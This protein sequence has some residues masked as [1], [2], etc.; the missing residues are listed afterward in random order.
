MYFLKKY[1]SLGYGNFRGLWSSYTEI[2]LLYCCSKK[3]E[4]RNQIGWLDVLRRRHQ[5]SSRKSL[6][7]AALH[8]PA[9]KGLLKFI[10][11]FMTFMKPWF[12]MAFSSWCIS[13]DHNYFYLNKL[14]SPLNILFAKWSGN[15]LSSDTARK[16][17]TFSKYYPYV[18]SRACNQVLSRYLITFSG[19]DPEKVL[20]PVLTTVLS[21]KCLR[22]WI[23]IL[24]FFIV[25]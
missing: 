18:D 22:E 10:D 7:R 19:P 9:K 2:M 12:H 23:W 8:H 5:L 11:L 3:G 16:N 17:T 6:P 13:G 15:S 20:L 25:G 21:S 1:I 4:G 24:Y 14:I